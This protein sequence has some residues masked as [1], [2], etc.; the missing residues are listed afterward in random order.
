MAKPRKCVVLRGKLKLMVA[1]CDKCG[2]KKQLQYRKNGS[3]RRL[4]GVSE[5]TKSQ[6]SG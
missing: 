2:H 5:L 4:C 3:E 6:Q 1:T